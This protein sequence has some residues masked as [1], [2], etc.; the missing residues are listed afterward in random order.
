MWKTGWVGVVLLLLASPC[1]AANDPA[2]QVQSVDGMSITTTAPYKRT[3]TY[4][5]VKLVLKA[6]GWVPGFHVFIDDPKAESRTP[7][8]DPH[9]ATTIVFYPVLDDVVPRQYEYEIPVRD[10]L[11]R[12][13]DKIEDKSEMPVTLVVVPE[14]DGVIED[15]SNILVEKV[16]FEP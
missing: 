1:V 15:V 11:D 6:A 4:Q 2:P 3:E 10:V 12:L 5:V 16:E 7:T 9:F 13:G 14:K 8:S